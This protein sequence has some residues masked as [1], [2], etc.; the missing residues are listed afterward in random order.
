[1]VDE[2]GVVEL[3]TFTWYYLIWPDFTQNY[4]VLLSF[5]YIF[6]VKVKLGKTQ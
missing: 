4:L 2:L 3:P 6:L 1:M 5:T